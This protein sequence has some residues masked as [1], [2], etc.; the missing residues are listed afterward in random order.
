MKF[1]AIALLVGLLRAKGSVF[2]FARVAMLIDV[3]Q[4]S[5]KPSSKTH[6]FIDMSRRF[7]DE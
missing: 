2:K 6:D 4:L 1:K 5:M 7:K 3:H